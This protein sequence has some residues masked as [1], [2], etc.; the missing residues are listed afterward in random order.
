MWTMTLGATW[1]TDDPYKAIEYGEE[2]LLLA[3]EHNLERQLAYSVIDLAPAYMSVGRLDEAR[4]LLL[5][6]KSRFEEL[7]DRPLL[8]QA[9]RTLG[10]LYYMQGQFARAEEELKG[11]LEIEEAI[12]N[13]WGLAANR[14]LLALVDLERGDVGRAVKVSVYRPEALFVKGRIL[15]AAG[16]CDEARQI[17]R[18]ALAESETIGEFR[19]R[20]QILACLAEV[21]EDEAKAAELRQRSMRP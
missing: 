5:E 8:A 7:D 11:G 1:V 18:Q 10:F 16:R 14:H 3:R 9:Y 17:W 15:Q 19:A 6:A 12:K 21:T 13:R 20:W 4:E 2:S